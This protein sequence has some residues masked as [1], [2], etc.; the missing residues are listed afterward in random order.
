MLRMPDG[1]TIADCKDYCDN[2]W[3]YFAMLNGIDCYCA[4][5]PNRWSEELHEHN[6]SK[7]CPLTKNQN[8]APVEL[9]CGGE[10]D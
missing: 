7:T 10:K 5:Q 6:C 2:G 8:E 1:L 3:N 4:K 9:P